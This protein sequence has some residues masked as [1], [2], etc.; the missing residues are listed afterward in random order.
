ML[1]IGILSAASIAPGAL[2]EPAR[3]VDGVEVTAVAARDRRRAEEFA[4]RHGIANVLDSYSALCGSDVV[5]AVY[6]CTPA[7]LHHQWT[8]AALAAG[9]HV[10]CEKP[11]AANA[12]EAAE[13]VAAGV[14]ADR[15][16]ME[17]FHWKYH[18]MAARIRAIC[19]GELGSIEHIE[20]SFTVGHLTNLAI[21]FDL[22][23][24]GG[25]L[26]DLGVY[27]LQWVR[28]VAQAEP[29][30]LSAHAV[31]DPPGLDLQ[32]DADLRFG[33]VGAGVT[34]HVHSSM[35]PGGPMGATLDV[36][37]SRGSLRVVNPLAPQMGNSLTVVV[38]DQSRTEEVERS[39]TYEHQLRA[40]VAAVA[41]GQPP[42]TGGA[43]SIATMTAVDAIYRAAG[44]SP[45]GVSVSR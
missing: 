37:G 23:L 18:P 28:W 32:M 33:D 42:L 22:S 20:A 29:T 26:M 10:L 8:L 15:V 35:Q 19:A 39:S 11:L 4:D 31:C 34:A 36:R 24:G 40:F 27:P 16:M 2:V 13:M 7:T 38:G 14:A 43:D 3:V 12:V 25:S 45:R 30:I 6:I 44:L 1:R 21:Q 5:D 41:S 9:K 17:A